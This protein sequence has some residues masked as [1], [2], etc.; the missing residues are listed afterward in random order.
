VS[1]G[2]KPAFPVDMD[3]TNYDPACDGMTYRQWLVGMAL[4]GL[5][6]NAGTQ[7]DFELAAEEAIGHADSVIAS[8]EKTNP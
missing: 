1:I 5:L 2:N 3:A 8:L 6:S 7:L 4:Q